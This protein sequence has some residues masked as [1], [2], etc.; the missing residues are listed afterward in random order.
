MLFRSGSPEGVLAAAA[1]RCVGGSLQAKLWPRD[2][3]EK[4]RAIA[5]GVDLER[6]YHTEDLCGGEDVFFAAT[7]V[8]GGDLLQ[9]VRYFG[10][11]AVSQ[12]IVM[13]CR[14]GTIRSIT[15][16]HD[17]TK[18]SMAEASQDG[19]AGKVAR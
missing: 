13:T 16:R 4:Q 6:V 11:G 18:R 3:A 15:T 2:P 8:T 10:H 19:S 9:G 14:T 1:I 7:G 5:A 17:F 12:S